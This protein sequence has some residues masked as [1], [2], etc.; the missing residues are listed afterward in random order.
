[1]RSLNIRQA[2]FFETVA[3][4][5]TPEVAEMDDAARSRMTE[6][7]D[8]ALHDRGESMRRQFGVFLE[9]VRLAPMVRYGRSFQGLDPSR[10]TAVLR[11]FQDCPISLLR[12]GFWG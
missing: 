6:I 10:R 11:W 1:M 2:S 7:V 9:V 5:I 8:A 3:A 12:K 4:T